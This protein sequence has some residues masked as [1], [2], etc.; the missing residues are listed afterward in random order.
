MV[1]VGTGQGAALPPTVC[2]GKVAL[3]PVWFRL[4]GGGN[5]CHTVEM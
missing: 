3:P 2:P 4:L 5:V 1:P